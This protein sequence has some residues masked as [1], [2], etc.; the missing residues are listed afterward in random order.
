LLPL[1]SSLIFE[2]ILYHFLIKRKLKKI[3]IYINN[4]RN[5]IFGKEAPQNFRS[6]DKTIAEGQGSSENG[7]CG[8]QQ[9]G[10]KTDSSGCFGIIPK[11]PEESGIWH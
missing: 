6:E 2:V 4:L 7:N 1:Q 8:A 5:Q 3:L 10:S 11:Q 9:A